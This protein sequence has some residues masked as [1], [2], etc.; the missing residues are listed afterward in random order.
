MTM[1]WITTL[2]PLVIPLLQTVAQAWG[3]A[4]GNSLQKIGEVIKSA[5]VALTTE[6]EAIGKAMFPS[7]A[8]GLHAAA[9][10]LLAAEAHTG[11]TAWV[12]AALN[13]AETAGV[14]SFGP[15]LVVDGILGPKT[16]AAILSLQS[17]LHLPTTGMFADAEISALQAV[18][19]KQ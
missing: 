3:S 4:T 14:V 11:A 1:N 6:L 10:V 19:A 2:L 18:L 5:P 12:Q 8:P 7:L 13:I 15:Q 17:L 9:V 16:K